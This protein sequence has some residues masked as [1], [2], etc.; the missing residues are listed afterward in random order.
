M[1]DLPCNIDSNERVT[2][3]VIGAVLLLGGLIGLGRM[4]LILV[5]II[6]LA[7]AIIGFCGIPMLSERFKLNEL[8]K[9]KEGPE[10]K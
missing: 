4:F 5:G 10:N 7:E 6:L 3:L 1:L 9:K 2:R 8:F